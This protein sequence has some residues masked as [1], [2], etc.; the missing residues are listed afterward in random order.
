M[1][2][3]IFPYDSS[4]KFFSVHKTLGSTEPIQPTYER[5]YFKSLGDIIIEKVVI[6]R[7]K[8]V[9]AWFFQFEENKSMMFLDDTKSVRK[10][11]PGPKTLIWAH[12][13]ILESFLRFF[14][15]PKILH[16]INFFWR[17]ADF[18][19]KS[20]FSCRVGNFFT[21]QYGTYECVLWVLNTLGHYLKLLGPDFGYRLSFWKNSIFSTSM[22]S[23]R[24]RSLQNPYRLS[25]KVVCRSTFFR[26]SQSLSNRS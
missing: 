26:F 17:N 9:L 13:D 7:K 4:T 3:F 21:S 25:S 23:K 22:A 15:Q 12:D 20:S 8:W 18:S 2:L 6:A 1:F 11:F 10:C 16:K 24:S 14:Q 19:W 5:G